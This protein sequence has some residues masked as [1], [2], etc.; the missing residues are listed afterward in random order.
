VEWDS[1]GAVEPLGRGKCVR[2][3]LSPAASLL[4]G[5]SRASD[6][7]AGLPF[8]TF[9]GLQIPNEQIG[10]LFPRKKNKN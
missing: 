9:P 1:D 8:Q 4:F 2:A 6:P 10:S 7:R 5:L 3:S